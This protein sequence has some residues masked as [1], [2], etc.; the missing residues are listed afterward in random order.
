MGFAEISCLSGEGREPKEALCT[1]GF[2]GRFPPLRIEASTSPMVVEVRELPLGALVVVLPLTRP[3][4]CLRYSHVRFWTVQRR[5]LVC[6][7]A[8]THFRCT[9]SVS[10]FRFLVLHRPWWPYNPNS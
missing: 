3:R 6:S 10:P 5:H 7:P 4:R 9:F 1:S 2:S 8:V